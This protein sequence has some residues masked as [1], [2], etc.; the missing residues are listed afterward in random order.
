MIGGSSYVYENSKCQR[1]CNRKYCK[2]DR[3]FRQNVFLE[4]DSGNGLTLW[5]FSNSTTLILLG[6]FGHFMNFR[7]VKHKSKWSTGFEMTNVTFENG[8]SLFSAKLNM[9]FYFVFWIGFVIAFVAAESRLSLIWLKQ[10]LK[11]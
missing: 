9:F 4:C 3:L 2:N 11:I 8:L 5:T 1:S 7:F 6:Q 10:R